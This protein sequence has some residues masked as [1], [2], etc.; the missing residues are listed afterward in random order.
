M[1]LLGTRDISVMAA[2]W[3][4]THFVASMR[5][6][7]CSTHSHRFSRGFVFT[8]NMLLFMESDISQLADGMTCDA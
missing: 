7:R 5:A 6:H 8:M 2:L 4:V 1:S 3:P